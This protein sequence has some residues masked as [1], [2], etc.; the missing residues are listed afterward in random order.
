MYVL[1]AVFLFWPSIYK[2][3]LA[4]IEWFKLRTHTESNLFCPIDIS[5]L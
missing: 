2:K 3:V 5:Y 1:Y 4:K